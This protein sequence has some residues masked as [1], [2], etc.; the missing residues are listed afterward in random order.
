MRPAVLHT[1]EFDRV[2][3]LPRRKPTLADAEAWAEAFTPEFLCV[4]AAGA[5]RPW[6]GY[7]VAEVVAN[8][9]GVL[10]FPVGVGKTLISR[11][12]PLALG[13]ERPLL[14]VP[15]DG[16]R[17][18]TLADFASYTGTWRAP[19]PPPRVVTLESLQ[20]A[21]KEHYFDEMQPDLI[22]IDEADELANRE[23]SVARR[24]DRYRVKTSREECVFVS[25]TGTPTRKSIMGYW[26]LMVWALLDDAPVPLTESE[27]LMWAAALD[28]DP[29]RGAPTQRPSPGPLGRTVQEARSWY[30][31]R[32][33]Q[34][35]GI[36]IVDGDSCAAPL[37]VRVRL[38][39]EDARLDEYFKVFALQDHDADVPDG[40]V[41]SD[42]L[43]RWRIDGFLG[44]GV[45]KRYVA[46]GPPERWRLARRTLAA[47]VRREIDA[48]TN[49]RR[50]LD[51]ESQVLRRFPY[52]APV[53][54]WL[55]VKEAYKPETEAVWLS[56]AT[57]ESALEWLRESAEPGIVWCGGVD[58]AQALATASGLPYFGA[59]GRDANGRRLH[60]ATAASGSILCSWHA[61]KK[62]FNLQGWKRQLLVH[63]PQSAKWYEQ[64]FGRSHR[65][66]QDDAV[67]CDVL[68]T[69]GG[70][71]DAFDAAIA[72]ASF[73]RSTVGLTQKILRAEIFRERPRVTPKNKY[74]WAR[75]S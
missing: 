25:M 16:L 72:E 3:A 24:L 44:T 47:F 61:N 8:R 35:P 15:G 62:G 9:G 5:L 36:V 28:A 12:L 69:S 2:S 55:A 38:A 18:K 40:L 6:Q 75:R 11:V 1:E 19:N 29:P 42:P 33:A 73:A 17:S 43:S 27:A 31:E 13:S 50:P 14:I 51:T 39:K 49:S 70:T 37:R 54:E 71:L 67:T 60:A 41:V 26:H 52:A 53:V 56:T 20:G 63:P 30:L 34:T 32:I 45:Y 57:I 46:P 74:R 48:S 7:G 58:F 22:M 66:G 23:S 64:I 4:G 68:A 21:S 65:S 10:M 59:E